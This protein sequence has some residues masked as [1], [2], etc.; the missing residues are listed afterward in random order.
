M[1]GSFTCPHC[2]AI[3]GQNWSG[4]TTPVGGGDGYAVS[5]CMSA[6]CREFALWVGSTVTLQKGDGSSLRMELGRDAKL[7][8]PPV[9]KGPEPNPDLDADIQKDF[10]E[11][12]AVL[13]LSPRASAALLR[14]CLQ[15][16]MV[17][18]GQPGKNIN[19][20]IAAL[21]KDGLRPDVQQAADLVRVTGND[22]VHPGQIATDD[23]AMVIALF[24]LLNIIAEDRVSQPARVKAIYEK[25]PEGKKDAIEKRD[26]T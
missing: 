9:R 11:A 17:Q 15:K 21:V 23:P 19:D 18:L 2:E 12:R 20:D 16:L 1:A 5:I 14:L 22:A 26:E 4:P 24:D 13:D 7:V 6:T 10:Q 25:V 8:W 3:T